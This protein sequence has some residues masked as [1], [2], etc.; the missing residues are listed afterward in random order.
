MPK[1]DWIRWIWLPHQVGWKLSINF[2]LIVNFVFR[3]LFQVQ[4]K[5][6]PIW[7]GKVFDRYLQSN[8]LFDPKKIRSNFDQK[9]F[10][11]FWARKVEQ[12]INSLL[13]LTFSDHNRILKVGNN[14][15][16]ELF[17]SKLFGCFSKL[18]MC[19]WHLLDKR[20]PVM[21]RSRL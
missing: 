18:L 7:F 11:K 4:W 9:L 19:E 2:S 15:K 14:S 21:L 20:R 3:D 10:Q 8:R 6:A 13:A 16:S 17:I 5:V 12:S 1:T